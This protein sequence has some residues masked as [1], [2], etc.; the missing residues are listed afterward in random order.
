MRT[1]GT[2]HLRRASKMKIGF[3]S[4]VTK[5]AHEGANVLMMKVHAEKEHPL[6]KSAFS[7]ALAE[8]QL[9]EQVNNLVCSLWPVNDALREAAEDIAKDDSIVD[10]QA[11]LMS[12]VQ[13]YIGTIQQMAQIK[14]TKAEKPMKTED[15]VAYP[16]GDFAYVPDAEKPSTWKLRLTSDPGGEPDT[17]IVGAAIAALGEGYRGN[18]VE[19]PEGDRQK[20][21]DR[22]KSAWKKLHPDS[23]ELPAVLKQAEDDDM[24]ELEKFKALAE[25]SDTHKAYHNSL[26]EADQEPFRKMDSSARDALITITKVEDES[27]EDLNGNK[28]TK[29]AAG[30]LFDVLKS[31]DAELRKARQETA[32]RKAQDTV[33]TEFAH[34]PGTLEDKAGALLAIE[35]LPEAVQTTLKLT[36]KQSDALWKARKDPAAPVGGGKSTDDLE[37]LIAEW[38]KSNPGKTRTQ[39]M[40]AVAGTKKGQEVIDAMRG[41]E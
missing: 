14:L 25:M 16:A 30:A 32:L 9:S 12:A 15:G 20:V 37:S 22:V 18:K 35:A 2:T 41:D 39:A 11:A 28:V 21:I 5:P 36:L 38:M 13:E 1:D 4:G 19:I 6:L 7:A 31:Q 26:P 24:S 27:F 34:L 33:N 10:K 3:L 17:R 40:Q 8:Q 23:E 29:S